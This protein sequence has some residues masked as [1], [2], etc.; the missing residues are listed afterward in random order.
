[1]F[2]NLL[3]IFLDS[4][5]PLCQRSTNQEIC[6]YCQQQ[7]TSCQLKN[8]CLFWQGDLPLFIWGNYEGRLKQ[9]ITSLK[10]ENNPQLGQLMGNWIGEAWLKFSLIPKYKK[11]IIIPIPIHPKKL[12]ERGFNQ[13]ELIA[14]GFCHITGY[15]LQSQGLIRIKETQ[16]LFGLKPT[17]R[18][19]EIS[20][21]FQI[22]KE[23]NKNNSQIPI[24][25][26]DDIYTTGTTV[27]EAAKTL[28]S[29]GFLVLGVVVLS[30]P[31]QG[32]N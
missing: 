19:K 18:A 15:S 22:S 25:L 4:K 23:F 9:A 7:I 26:I 24:L 1:M 17:E 13:A 2:K 32:T 16:A 8:P 20:Q 30:R 21:S 6:Q 11:L 12:Q 5:C 31:R 10:F 28:S 29:Q 3:A 14:K 27:K